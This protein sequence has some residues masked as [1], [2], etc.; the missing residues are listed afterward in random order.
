M[1]TWLALP[2]TEPIG[3]YRARIRDEPPLDIER[4]DLSGLEK[5]SNQSTRVQ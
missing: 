2:A 3:F 5:R 4:I 1:S